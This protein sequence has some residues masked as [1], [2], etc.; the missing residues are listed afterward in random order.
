MQ[1]NFSKGKV[2]LFALFSLIT[3]RC[4]RAIHFAVHLFTISDTSS[5]KG[6]TQIMIGNE[7]YSAVSIK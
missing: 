6:I 3:L 5:S 1:G 2:T 7:V 4:Y